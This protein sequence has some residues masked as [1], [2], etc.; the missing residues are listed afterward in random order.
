MFSIGLLPPPQSGHD[1]ARLGEIVI[2]QFNERFSVHPISAEI[3]DVQSL[4]RAELRKLVAG[5]SSVALIFDP[6]FAWVIY[7]EESTCFVQEVLALD[8]DFSSHLGARHTLT[9]DGNRISEWTTDLS[10][11]ERFID[12]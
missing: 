12:A 1:G 7:R 10:S 2:G 6:R 8:G 9:E 3:Q 4:W 11:I 5:A